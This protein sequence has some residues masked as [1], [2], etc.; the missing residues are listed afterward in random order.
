MN[1]LKGTW[2]LLK[3]NFRLDR[4]KLL[5]W[6][7]AIVGITAITLPELEKAYGTPQK[8]VGYASSVAPSMVSRLLGGAVTGPTLGEIAVVETFALIAVLIALMNIFTITR[9]T[10]AEEESGRG[11]LVGSMRVGRQAA[12]TAALIKALLI[13]SVIGVLLYTVFV[14]QHLSASGSLAYSLGITGVG[15]FFAALSAVTAQLFESSRTANS[16]AGLVFGISFLLRGLGDAFGAVNK[17]GLGVTTSWLSWL[18]P[19]G[20]AT[21]MLPFSL[22][23]RWWLLGL[24]GLAINGFIALAYLLLSRRDIGSGIFSEKPGASQ[25]APGLLRKFGLLWRLNRTAFIAWLFGSV[26]MGSALGAVAN[27]FSDLIAGNEE[28]QQMLATYG[29]STS[30]VDLMFAATFTITGILLAAYGLQL[31]LRMRSE[32]TSGRLEATFATP[33][34]RTKWMLRSVIFTLT[35]ALIILCATGLA[36][37]FVY[38]LVDGDVIGKTLRMGVAIMVHAP[39]LLVILG[40]GLLAFSIMPRFAALISWTT[41]AA[42]LLI[43]QLGAVLG[44]PQWIINLSPFSHTPTAPAS[45]IALKPLFILSLIA[46]IMNVA[47]LRLFKRRDITTE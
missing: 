9:H 6:I 20:W 3:L 31:L 4:I 41:L 17:D 14:S 10:R 36:A 38:G 42:C 19:L 1:A 11:E 26:A 24:F 35:T 25:A 33:L 15:I 12:L 23:E 21:N 44:L 39:A 37:G 29:Q 7:L 47:A 22:A 46:L 30:P 2:R 32:E 13:N 16:L 45:T 28:M 43:I 18:S 27:E 34:S 40:C 5:I 8:A